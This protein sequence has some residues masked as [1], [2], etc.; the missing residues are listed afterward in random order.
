MCTFCWCSLIVECGLLFV[1]CSCCLVFG[2]ALVR[3]L[4]YVLI[5]V[6]CLLC[7]GCCLVCVV[8]CLFVCSCACLFVVCS[9][10]CVMC[11]VCWFG[12]CLLF[13]CLCCF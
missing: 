10:R 8:C 5:V 4:G 13:V 11:V 1:V 3:V 9:C 2:V 6:C 7:V 12:Y